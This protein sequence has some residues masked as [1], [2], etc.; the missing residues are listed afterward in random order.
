MKSQ[1]SS[2]TFLS[3]VDPVRFGFLS[4]FLCLKEL[5]FHLTLT[6]VFRSVPKIIMQYFLCTV[7]YFQCPSY[8]PLEDLN[9]VFKS[10][11]VPQ[12]M[13][14]PKQ[15]WKTVYMRFSQS[16]ELLLTLILKCLASLWPSS[17]CPFP[18]VQLKGHLSRAF[19]K[20]RSLLSTSTRGHLF[21]S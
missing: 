10:F 11:N 14:S 18:V 5:N 1:D 7:I 8:Q 15:N 3:K 17:S 20:R 2:L 16:G 9:Q 13:K 6:V 4:C 21:W 12:V 19:F